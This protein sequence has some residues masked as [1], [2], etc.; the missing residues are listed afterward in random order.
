MSIG[1]F[2]VDAIKAWNPLSP[3]AYA[4]RDRNK[5]YRK[6]RRKAKRGEPMSETETEILNTTPQEVGMAVN[7]GL[8]SSSN[9]VIGGGVANIIIEVLQIFWPNFVLSPEM[10]VNLTLIIAW[11]CSRFTKTPADAGVV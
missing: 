8:R 11:V 6:A 5:A 3:E 7:T 1:K 9:M 10:R 2:A 4:R